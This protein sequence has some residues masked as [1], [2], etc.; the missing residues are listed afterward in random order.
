M[1][2]GLLKELEEF[3]NEMLDV[4]GKIALENF[5]E[6]REMSLKG[7]SSPVT[8]TDIKI[9]QYI[10]TKILE[11][12]PNHKIIGEELDYVDGTENITWYI[13]PI[14][15]RLSS[16]GGV[17]PSSLAWPVTTGYVSSGYKW[18]R[19]GGTTSFHGA[20]ILSIWKYRVVKPPP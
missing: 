14:D 12:Y 7:D 5:R 11:N 18:R 20:S 10:R 1:K 4:S 2:K 19:L 15:D 6:I 9:E 17:A 3:I 16:S 8:K 13:D